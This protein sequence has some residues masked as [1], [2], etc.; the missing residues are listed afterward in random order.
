[1]PVLQMLQLPLFQTA[2]AV[3]NPA[4]VTIGA[5][6]VVGFFKL[7]FVILAF[8]Y[9]LFAFVVTRQIKVMRTTL[10]TPISPVVRVVGYVHLI[11]ALIVF[12][13]FV[14]FL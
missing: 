7:L 13:G 14:L 2:F 11:F 3:N 4:F 8:L 12:V 6:T 1:M 10:I 5:G 9:L